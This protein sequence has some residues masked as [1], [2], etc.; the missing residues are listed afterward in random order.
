MDR[1]W[2]AEWTP[3]SRIW[4]GWPRLAH[5]WSGLMDRARREIADVVDALVQHVPVRVAAGADE[6][7]AIARRALPSAAEI[8]MIPTGDIWLRDTGPV[9]METGTGALIANQ[10]AFNG[11]GGKFDMPG[12]TETAAALAAAE[13]LPTRAYPF[14]LEGGA[15][16]GDGA[17]R[18]L[19]TR[20]CL[21]H[22]NRNQWTKARAET[23]LDES[24]GARSV[25]WIDEGL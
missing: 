10:F 4:V 2:P 24:L 21:L 1:Y 9:V 17:G 13:S 19:T 7:A 12:D 8:V 23:A 11:W 16:E 5:E 20:Q 18:V 15:I 14:V 25:Y 6:A 22:R 3:Q